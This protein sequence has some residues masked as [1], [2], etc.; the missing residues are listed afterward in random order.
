LFDELEKKYTDNFCVQHI[1]SQPEKNWK[2][3]KGRITKELTAEILKENFSHSKDISDFYLCG[4]SEMMKNIIET[5]KESGI[6]KNRIH[7]EIYTTTVVDQD[8]E[9]EDIPREV[10]IIFKDEEH[11]LTINPGKSI[12]HTALD[13]GLDLPN[14]CQYGNCSTCRA[15]LL[16]GQLKLIDQ[17]ALS[18]EELEKGYCLTCVGY[19][20]SDNVV[21]LYED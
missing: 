10:T 21:I 19:P 18:D 8:E 17:T 13:A 16:S 11:K 5:L 9:V 3:T 6:E 12:L 7:R 2:G 15:K 20:V 4:P 1:L 14:S